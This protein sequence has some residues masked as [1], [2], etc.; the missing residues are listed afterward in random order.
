[1]RLYFA[2]LFLLAKMTDAQNPAQI[3]A[4]YCATL[5]AGKA[6]ILAP[7]RNL[8]LN[9]LILLRRDLTP[10]LAGAALCL[11]TLPGLQV[12]QAPLAL[13]GIIQ[14]QRNGKGGGGSRGQRLTVQTSTSPRTD[15]KSKIW[16]RKWE[17]A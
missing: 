8:P 5:A 9:A 6:S 16:Y 17:I 13:G 1:M 7:K 4:L 10:G 2:H 11:M 12:G 15:W 3:I 14:R